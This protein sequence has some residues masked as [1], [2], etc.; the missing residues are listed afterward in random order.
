MLF[1]AIFPYPLKKYLAGDSSKVVK[2]G[3]DLFGGK[4][5]TLAFHDDSG[6]Q[7]TDSSLL[8]E[9]IN[10]L[11]KRVN[12]LGVSEVAIRQ[13]GDVIVLDFPSSQ[14]MNASELIHSSKM[15]FHIVN[16]NFSPAHPDN[17]SIV[18]NFLTHVWEEALVRGKTDEESINEIAYNYL[19]GDH[20]NI[21]TTSKMLLKKGLALASSNQPQKSVLDTKLSKIA[22]IRNSEKTVQVPLMVVFHHYALKGADLCDI[23]GSYDPSKGHFLS[24]GVN[25]TTSDDAYS[26]QKLLKSWTERYAHTTNT[27]SSLKWRM[28]AILNGE[29]ITAP[30]LQEPIFEQASITG[31]FSHHEVDKLTRDLKAGSMRYTPKI[32]SES[33][34]SAELGSKERSQGI[35]A[36]ALSLAFV[37]ALML[38]Y[39]RLSGLFASIALIMNFLLM[40]AILQHFGATITLATL[41]GVVLTLG[42]AVDANV[43]IFERIREELTRVQ[44]LSTAIQRGFQRALSAI[45]DANITTIIAAIIL[46]QFDSGPIK[47][48]SLALIVG[49]VS[50]LFTALF[51]TRFLFSLYLQRSKTEKL[52]MKNLFSLS[53]V[54]FMKKSPVLIVFASLLC[55]GSFATAIWKNTDMLGIDF[56]GGYSFLLP[57]HKNAST[58][59][60]PMIEK[61]LSK[62]LNNAHCQV[63]RLP[64]DNSYRIYLNQST[65][66]IQQTADTLYQALKPTSI[67]VNLTSAHQLQQQAVMV[68]GQISDRMQTQALMGMGLALLAILAYITIR[69]E[70][71]F[72]IAA[73]VALFFDCVVTLAIIVLSKVC[74]LMIEID[75]QT[76]AAMMT[77]IG[78]SLNDT[79][80][81]FDRIRENRTSFSYKSPEI[82]ANTALC[83]TFSRTIM[84]SLTTLFALLSLVFLGGASIFSFSYVMTIGVCVG[85]LSTYFVA[86]KL[87]AYLEQLS[88]KEQHE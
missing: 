2:W 39:Y 9:C 35:F 18:S 65:G 41:A 53:K 26:P 72:A 78:Y 70:Y 71:R 38:Y 82:Q 42:M 37:I 6:D 23:Q 55:L 80:V 34:V 16:E 13:Q 50:S 1:G 52:S 30:N 51:V 29:V 3:L 36:T 44:E 32:L 79:I 67:P 46:F 74:G 63:Q 77:I 28:A 21:N 11:H 40:W 45:L 60:T 15:T 73:T 57:L 85:T 54:N 8:S 68:S 27:Q 59:Y 88:L 87:W 17:G 4:T 76:I 25:T 62:T 22:V 20:K 31:N 12:K 10:A 19:Y 84:T 47:G 66:S 83:N 69:F 64:S 75:L 14:E 49:I 61:A 33:T 58:N 24:F 81:V 43:L 5:V 7:I 48:F 56:K 86:S